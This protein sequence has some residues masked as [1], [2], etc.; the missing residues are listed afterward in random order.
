MFAYLFPEGS[1]LNPLVVVFG[2]V[3]LLWF[4]RTLNKIARK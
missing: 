1:I 2:L 4:I 3:V